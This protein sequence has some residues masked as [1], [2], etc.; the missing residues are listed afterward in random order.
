MP[1]SSHIATAPIVTTS[2]D[3][4]EGKNEGAAP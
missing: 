3:V 2:A 1:S 4:V